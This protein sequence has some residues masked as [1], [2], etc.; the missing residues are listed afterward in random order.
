MNAL[1]PE[2]DIP[3]DFQAP[4]GLDHERRELMIP[5]RDGVRLH[6]VLVLPRQACGA[7]IVL[8]RTPYG[9]SLFTARGGSRHGAMRM[10]AYLGEL[11]EAGYIVAV[12]D[13]R[14]KHKSEGD[15]VL[16]RPLRGALN[17]TQTDHATDAWDTID[18]LVMN[19]P[20]SNARVGTLG[21]SYDGFTALMSL[22]DSHPA[23]RACVP[24][25]PMVDCWLGDDWFHNGAFRQKMV[26][27]YVYA[28]TASKASELAWPAACH[29]EYE[30][31]LKAGNASGVA[32]SLGLD[33]LPFWQRLTEHPSYDAYWQ[34]Q[35][36]DKALAEAQ[37]SVPTLHVHSQWDAEDIHGALAAHAAMGGDGKGSEHNHL[38]IGPWSHPS[39]GFGD[40]SSLG[41]IK[42]GSDT[43]CW[44]RR[45]V[46][47]RFLDRHLKCSDAP[48]ASPVTAF[49]SGSN[50]WLE[51]ECWPPKGTQSRA[52]YLG[53]D[54]ALS[55]NPPCPE[56]RAAAWDEYTA[57]P[58]KPVTYKPRPITARAFGDESWDAWLV[59]DQRFAG[60]RPDVLTYCSGLLLRPLRLAGQPVVHLFASTSATDLDWVVKL[61]DV[62]PDE[63]PGDPAMGGYQLPLAM[64]ILRGRYRDD[65]AHP[66]AVPAGQV[67][68]YEIRLPHIAHAVLPGHRLM[69]QIQSSWFPLYDRN[70]QRFVENIFFASPADYTSA[71]H[72]VHRAPA[73]ASCVML[74]VIE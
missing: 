14:G 5:M 45:E 23:L 48:T 19:V 13:V 6:T 61:I 32:Q 42:F 21:I 15:Y 8:E 65:P 46:M 36:V 41:P 11:L 18:W 9:A 24:M 59:S 25:N 73:A 60:D 22:I 20:E 30:M 10:F 31:W 43:A 28:Q 4:E 63:V 70:P 64:E 49:E 39:V 27:Q 44:F 54:G 69:V 16:M 51:H 33:R 29:D 47:L 17:R 12:Q 57:N 7:P 35:A 2:R 71:T 68:R 62:Y 52:L 26:A 56:D 53:P 72:R 55:F 74:P 38:V 40:G 66:V 1:P 58:A 37:I 50:V 3:P 67:V 34:A